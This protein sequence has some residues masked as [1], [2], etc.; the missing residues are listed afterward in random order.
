MSYKT[1]MHIHSV[2]SDGWATPVE[3]VRKYKDDDYDVVSLTDHD[4][5]A[6]VHDA[7]VS[8][9]ALRIQVIP[10]IELSTKKE[11]D[12]WGYASEIHVLGYNIDIENKSLL[13]LSER[14]L[15]S[16]RER[17]E[18]LIERLRAEGYNLDEELIRMR[19]GG[20]YIAKPDIVRALEALGVDRKDGWSM[21]DSRQRYMPSV[22]EGISAIRDAKGIPVLAH[23][24]KISGLRPGE[25]GFF[26]RLSDLL[27]H[28]KKAGLGGMECFHPSANQEHRLK[29]V[30]LAGRYH[31]HITE[32]SDFHGNIGNKGEAL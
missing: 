17:N 18:A 13:D 23:P 8:G 14:L 30:D 4:N 11:L 2:Y 15:R 5:V 3:L 22:E 24:M 7:L 12:G 26:G 20:G 28:L 16:R 31:L 19:N 21:L 9:E 27:R 6:G 25:E 1:D 29:L 10:G 32:G